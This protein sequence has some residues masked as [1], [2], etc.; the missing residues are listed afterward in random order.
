M[1]Y[2]ESAQTSRGPLQQITRG[3]D[4]SRLRHLLRRGFAVNWPLM[5][6]GIGMVLTLLGTLAGLVLDNRVITGAPAWL[7]PTKFAISVGVYSFT[8]LWLLTFVRGHKRL[9]SFVATVT[10]IG[11]LVEMVVIILQVVRGTTSHFNFSTPLDAALFSMMGTLIIAVWVMGLIT[12]GLLL[13]Q[14]MPDPAFAWSLRLGMVIAL[15]GM[16]VAYL[17]VMPSAEQ[18]AALRA[19]QEIATIGAHSVGVRDGGPGLPIVGWSTTGGD[20]RIPHFVGLHAMQVLPLAGWT[21]SRRRFAS[22]SAGQR[23]TLVWVFG[24]GY[25][26]LMGL[27]TWQ[28]L[29]G[30]SIIA[31]DA[32]T[33]QA[34]AALISAT[35]LATILTLA[36][37]RVRRR[38][39]AER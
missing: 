34:L 1:L 30:Q 27:L 5:V 2:T 29:R 20:L 15:A 13:F 24:L 9:V 6:V 31:P 22:L 3:L 33:L 26:S 11:F 36:Y 4:L 25:L 35:A 10:A 8:F 39:T 14:R 19:G 23:T 28:A 32:L 18:M 16:G 7:K 17:M 38:S 21:L 12:A 37:S